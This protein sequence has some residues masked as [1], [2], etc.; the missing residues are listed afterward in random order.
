MFVYCLFP[1]QDVDPDAILVRGFRFLFS[2]GT[3]LEVLVDT[4]P[5]AKKRRM[6]LASLAPED[7]L[8]VYNHAEVAAKFGADSG[9][10]GLVHETRT[11]VTEDEIMEMLDASAAIPAA[12]AR[13]MAEVDT[14]RFLQVRH[15]LL[16][17]WKPSD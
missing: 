2:D 16:V 4:T 3:I 1:A 6:A 17:C 15:G 12:L 13:R 11:S 9:M 8:H 7:M 10:S 14:R 5:A